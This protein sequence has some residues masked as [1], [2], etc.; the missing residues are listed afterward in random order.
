MAVSIPG[1]FDHVT[2]PLKAFRGTTQVPL[3]ADTA[4]TS[5]DEAVA[6]VVLD[7]AAGTVTATRATAAAAS[8]TVTATAGGGLTTTMIVNVETAVATSLAFDE[9]NA[10][11]S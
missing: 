11:N 8:M 7:L 4:V 9:A 2:V 5:S 10:T 1:A 3:P 6:S